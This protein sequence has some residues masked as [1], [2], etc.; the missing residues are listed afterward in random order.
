[1]V[2]TLARLMCH[3]DVPKMGRGYDYDALY[4]Y[5]SEKHSWFD[6][7]F[8]AA[9][10]HWVVSKGTQGRVDNAHK[11]TSNQLHTIMNE[12]LLRVENDQKRE[13][14]V[15]V[16]EI[17]SQASGSNSGS[18][19]AVPGVQL[20]QGDVRRLSGAVFLPV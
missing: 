3:S 11:L 8:V 4:D 2:T 16:L 19:D 20:I 6:D 12:R 9:N 5:L 7:D 1:M 13:E 10:R 17:S 14:R 15:R 18:I